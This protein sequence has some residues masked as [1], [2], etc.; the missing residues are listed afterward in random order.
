MSELDKFLAAKAR[1]RKRMANLTV[2]QKVAVIV[3][4]QKRRA[5]ILAQRGKKQIVWEIEGLP[6]ISDIWKD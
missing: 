3:E 1:L 2:P 6:D 5:P 4:L